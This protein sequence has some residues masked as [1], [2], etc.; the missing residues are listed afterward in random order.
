MMTLSINWLPK[1]RIFSFLSYINDRIVF[2]AVKKTL[3]KY[4]IND[5]VYV[6]SFNPLYG[7]NFPETFRPRKTIYHCVDDISKAP[8]LWK[9]GRRL[10]DEAVR[11]ADLVITTSGELARLKSDAAENVHILPNAANVGLFQRAILERL[12]K[13]A[14]IKQIP[15]ERP[16]ITYIGNICHRLDYNL[17]LSIADGLPQYTLLMVGPF[18]TSDYRESGLDRRPNVIFT[19]QKKLEELPAYLQYSHCCIIPFLCNTLTKSIYP[20]KINEYLSAGKP[21]VTTPFSEDIQS[22][23]GVIHITGEQDEFVSA[24]KEVILTDNEEQQRKRVDFSTENS[25]ENRANE[26]WKI[27]NDVNHE[28]RLHTVPG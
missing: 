2:R 16:L 26:F 22:F 17:L 25:W 3:T 21:V 15:G 19:G 27:V 24:I 18:G 5:F 7:N 12:Q 10:E 11:R 6:N 4:S 13:P 14:E 9:H 20:L 1:G 8:N 28:E 23:S